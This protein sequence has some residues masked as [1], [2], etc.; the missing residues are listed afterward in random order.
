MI[1]FYEDE[2]AQKAVNMYIII[3]IASVAAVLLW[4]ASQRVEAHF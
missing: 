4:S 3:M 1:D 2:V